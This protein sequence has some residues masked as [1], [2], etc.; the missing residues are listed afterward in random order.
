MMSLV[1]WRHLGWQNP[2]TKHSRVLLNSSCLFACLPICT[3]YHIH[4][5]TRKFPLSTPT[6]LWWVLSDGLSYPRHSPALL[7]DA[8]NELCTWLHHSSVWLFPCSPVTGE[9][10]VFSSSWE[11]QTW[12]GTASPSSLKAVNTR[13]PPEFV[14]EWQALPSPLLSPGA[15]FLLLPA[16]SLSME[17]D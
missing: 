4:K 1:C 17:A 7:W 2:R 13:G 16:F 11:T 10:L 3:L 5:L 8:A 15:T 12:H 9:L 14:L 6:L